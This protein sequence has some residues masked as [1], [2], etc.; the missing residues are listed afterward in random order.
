MVLSVFV[1][2]GPSSRGI[3]QLDLAPKSR[4]MRA[5]METSPEDKINFRTRAWNRKSAIWRSGARGT[6]QS[7]DSATSSVD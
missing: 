7:R 4:K 6:L 5:A 1:S 3:M 2:A